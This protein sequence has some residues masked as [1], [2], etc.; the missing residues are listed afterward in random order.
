M[1]EITWRAGNGDRLS[2]S[3]SEPDP[4][5][6]QELAADASLEPA[7]MLPSAMVQRDARQQTWLAQS[8]LC[9][10]AGDRRLSYPGPRAK[11]AFNLLCPLAARLT[12]SKAAYRPAGDG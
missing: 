2:E 11:G 5:P 6:E 10:S 3:Q 9:S 12:A 1:T 4:K 7:R 8:S